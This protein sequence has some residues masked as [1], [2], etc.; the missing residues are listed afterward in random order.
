MTR[1]AEIGQALNTRV[2][3]TVAEIRQITNDWRDLFHRS[4]ATAFQSPDWLLPWIEIFSP[5]NMMMVEVRCSGR[6]VGLAPFLVYSRASERVLGFMGGGVSDYLDL[7]VD[8]SFE[9]HVI[10]EVLTTA[11][12][13]QED[14]TVLNLTD[15]P[16]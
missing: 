1:S 13:A 2:L 6:L 7:L 9:S 14:W 10:P 16:Y 11:I 4:R 15:L 5:Q 8:G 12:S 3:R